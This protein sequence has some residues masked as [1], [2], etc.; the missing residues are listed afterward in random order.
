MSDQD[1][2]GPKATPIDA[3]KQRAQDGIERGRMRLAMARSRI[4]AKYRTPAAR[5]RGALVALVIGGAFLGLKLLGS[6]ST[7]DVASSLTN[8]TDAANAQ[9]SASVAQTTMGLVDAPATAAVRMDVAEVRITDDVLPAMPSDAMPDA[10]L[11]PAPI[12]KLSGLRDTQAVAGEGPCK[13]SVQAMPLA[14]A[15][16]AIDISA[17]CDG[18]ARVDV[19]QSDLQIA[20]ALGP[21]GK[22]TVEL[23]ALSA[24]PAVSVLVTDR[25]PVTVQ[26]EAVDFAMYHRAILHWQ[27]MAG[28]ELHA[29]EGGGTYGDPGHV[30]PETPRT[31]AHA[32]SGNGGFL[33]S[34]G[35]DGLDNAYMALVYTVPQ[36]LEAEISIEAPV[37]VANCDQTVH[38]GTIQTG[39]G[40]GSDTQELS[41]TM[42]AC[43]A[44]GDFVLL[45]SLLRPIVVA[46]N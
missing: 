38:G 10:E 13:V 21:D 43:D 19:L 14:A 28:L 6:V 35:D 5:R 4:P 26:T 32:L 2:S 44:V 45:G 11:A 16:V 27:G 17:P 7:Q 25:D 30:S 31:I 20:V 39:P 1:Q 3:L 9:L 23:P 34:L 18:G 36:G 37:T 42:P 29:F 40:A 12:R 41:M 33:T 22:T 15:T 46:A 24:M 8:V